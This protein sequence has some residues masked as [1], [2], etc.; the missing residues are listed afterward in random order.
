[1]KYGQMGKTWDSPTCYKE[2]FTLPITEKPKHQVQEITD[3]ISF[4]CVYLKHQ[5]C[6]SIVTKLL[7]V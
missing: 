3:T 5:H 7:T 4:N 2:I 6:I 1:M